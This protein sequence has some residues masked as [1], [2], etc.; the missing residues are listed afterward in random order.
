MEAPL[1]VAPRLPEEGGAMPK[2]FLTDRKV[3]SLAPAAPGTRYD[4]M[5]E[6]VPGFGV[7]VTDRG[8][9]TFILIARFPRLGRPANQPTRRAV[10]EF[11]N[12]EG[13]GGSLSE[14]RAKAREWKK[15]IKKGIDPREH[16]EA[17]RIA[18]EGRKALSAAKE[19]ADR[20]GI[21]SSVAEAFLARPDFKNQRRCVQVEREIR[22]ELLDSTRNPWI[23]RHVSQVDDTDIASLVSA[24][25]ERP[26]P[27]QA[28]NV[29]SHARVIFGWARRP[30]NRKRYG[31][32][33]SP[34]D[35]VRPKDIG[36]K[37]ESRQRVL[38]DQEIGAFWRAACRMGYPNGKAFQ[39]LLVTGQRKSEI[40]RAS[41]REIDIQS[42]LLTVPAERFKSDA[43]HMVP[44]SGL[45]LEIL[46]TFPRFSKEGGGD[47]V[48]STLNGTKPINGFSKA[49]ADLDRRMLGSLRAYARMRGFDPKKVAMEPFVLHDLRRTVRTRLSSL[50][51]SEPVAEMVIG[52]AKKGLSRVYDQHKYLDEMREALDEWAVRLT[53]VVGPPLGNRGSQTVK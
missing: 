23:A 18:E 50:K 11:Q 10:G 3:R 35:G 13:D 40:A 44:L 16:A 28:Y 46:A 39:L 41:W 4:I 25:R 26:A 42:K 24:I 52:H 9:K 2:I 53:L 8:A 6:A 45:A 1:I 38:S 31:L 48:F 15:L 47:F 27:Y 49:K 7:R 51:V 17:E 21:F 14:A 37:K 30:E 22:R 20:E 29:L 36:L 19:I 5:D 32:S 33:R 43:S 34:L 12:D